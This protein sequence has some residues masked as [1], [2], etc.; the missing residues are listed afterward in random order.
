M[1]L[2]EG[3]FNKTAVRF[4]KDSAKKMPSDT[5]YAHNRVMTWSEW[6]KKEIEIPFLDQVPPV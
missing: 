6:S 4:D 2:N 3:R 1:C 5:K